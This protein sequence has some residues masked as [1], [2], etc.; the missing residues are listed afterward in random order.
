MNDSPFAYNLMV[1]TYRIEDIFHRPGR[2]LEGFGIR[3]GDTGVD[4][5][6]GPGRYLKTASHLVGA[7]GRV[8]AA[9]VS[10]IALEHVQKRIQKECLTNIVPYLIADDA[11]GIPGG[12]ADVIYALDMFH[13]I[14][15]PGAFFTE[16]RRIIKPAGTLYLKDGRQ[17]RRATLEK[18]QASPLWDI[19]EEKPGYVVLQPQMH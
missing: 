10:L 5:G 6:C 1:T 2:Q 11:C 4:Y 9:D 7:R 19:A 16:L 18:V 14:G 12:C 3:E 15:E 17:T 8:Y 13:R